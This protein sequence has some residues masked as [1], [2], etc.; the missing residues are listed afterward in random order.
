MHILQ[1]NSP[2]QGNAEFNILSGLS[3]LMLFDSS[4]QYAPLYSG[5]PKHNAP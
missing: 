3:V 2:Q 4:F 5:L 1:C